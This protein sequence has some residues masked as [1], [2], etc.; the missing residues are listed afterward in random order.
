MTEVFGPSGLKD[1][2]GC[3]VLNG[4]KLP[5]QAKERPRIRRLRLCLVEDDEIQ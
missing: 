1:K 3:T 2:L 4:S 5:M